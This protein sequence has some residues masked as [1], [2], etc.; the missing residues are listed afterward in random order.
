MSSAIA[1]LC[2][3]LE[4]EI[5]PTNVRGGPR[6]TKAGNV[7]R[8]LLDEHGE[9]HVVIALRTIIESEGNDTA[10]TS[11]VIH[12]VSDLIL[13]HPGWTDR[14]LAWIEAFDDIDLLDLAAKA[15]ANKK[16]VPARPAMA[17]MLYERLVPTFEPPKIRKRAL[18]K[19][20]GMGVS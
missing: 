3:D 7:L 11:P 2:A 13:A 18:L 12:G 20:V 10:L 9:G 17:A 1:R 6:R 15:K 16:A 5:V 8:R 4:I 19:R 14:G